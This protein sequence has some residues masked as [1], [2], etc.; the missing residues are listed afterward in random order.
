MEYPESIINRIREA[1]VHID[2]VEEKKMFQGICF[3]VNGK[4][5]VCVR[6]DEMMCRIGPDE[7]EAVLEKNGCR[8]MIHRGRTMVGFVFINPEGMRTKADFDN[9]I[10]LSLD[11]NKKAKASNK[12]DKKPLKTK[13]HEKFN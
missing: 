2:H 7:Y 4:M 11:F 10:K 13:Q 12:R 9:W 8:P 5:C 1:L 3:M 6:K